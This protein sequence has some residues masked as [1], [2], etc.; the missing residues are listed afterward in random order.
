[1]KTQMFEGK[2][3]KHSMKGP[4]GFNS[5]SFRRGVLEYQT[6]LLMYQ[7]LLRFRLDVEW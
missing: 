3:L 1:M 4:H 5:L 6:W 7:Y 2:H